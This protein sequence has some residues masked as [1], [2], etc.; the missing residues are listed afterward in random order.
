MKFVVISMSDTS[1][2]VLELST[3]EELSYYADYTDILIWKR[4]DWEKEI[5]FK[6]IDFALKIFDYWRE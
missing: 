5:G 6:D 2:Y 1:P 3:L 4:E